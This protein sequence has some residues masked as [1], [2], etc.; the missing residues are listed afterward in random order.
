MLDHRLHIQNRRLIIRFAF[1]PVKILTARR[2][3]IV[4]IRPGRFADEIEVAAGVSVDST[5]RHPLRTVWSDPAL[6]LLIAIVAVR[7]SPANLTWV[8]A[9]PHRKRVA[10]IE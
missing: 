5:R 8:G 3:C 1:L 6:R 7:Y 9:S 10:I 2:C 4:L